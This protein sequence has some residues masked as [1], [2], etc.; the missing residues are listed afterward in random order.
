MGIIKSGRATPEGERKTDKVTSKEIQ[1]F[2][3]W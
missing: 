3:L 2:S 1:V